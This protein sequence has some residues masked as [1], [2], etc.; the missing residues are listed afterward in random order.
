M[1]CAY[2]VSISISPLKAAVYNQPPTINK[3]ST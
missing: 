2:D 3:P 1:F